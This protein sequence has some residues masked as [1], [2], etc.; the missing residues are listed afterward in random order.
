MANV[1]YS[2]IF[3]GFLPVQEDKSKNSALF[4][5]VCLLV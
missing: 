4:V 2:T 5:F 1:K 3:L